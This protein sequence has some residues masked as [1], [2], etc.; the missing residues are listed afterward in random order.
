MTTSFRSDID[1]LATAQDTF[2]NAYMSKITSLEGSTNQSIDEIKDLKGTVIKGGIHEALA[3]SVAQNPSRTK[4]FITND[5]VSVQKVLVALGVASI[6]DAK[7]RGVEIHTPPQA[8]GLT[9]DEVYV[10][11]NYTSNTSLFERQNAMM[12]TATTRAKQLLWIS[13]FK[14][15]VQSIDPSLEAKAEAN[16]LQK[17]EMLARNVELEKDL[18]AIYD[19]LD[20]KEVSKDTLKETSKEPS[21]ENPTPEN[22]T[23]LKREPT[24]LVNSFEA[25]N[26]QASAFKVQGDFRDVRDMLK[27]GNTAVYLLRQADDKYLRVWAVVPSGNEKV[28]KKLAL[29]TENELQSVGVNPE[30]LKAY[31]LRDYDDT[32]AL[33]GS[34]EAIDPRSLVRLT[35]NEADHIEY[36]YENEPQP[37]L[38]ESAIHSTVRNWATH[39]LKGY[40]TLPPTPEEAIENWK[41][42]E[43]NPSQFVS[44]I[45]PHGSGKNDNLAKLREESGIHTI[46]ENQPY[47]VIQGFKLKGSSRPIKHQFISLDAAPMNSARNSELLGLLKQFTDLGD[48]FNK[49]LAS[50]GLFNDT[51]LTPIG[52]YLNE[53]AHYMTG[54]FITKLA[55]LYR[56]ESGLSSKAK[57]MIWNKD[58]VEHLTLFSMD[59]RNKAVPYYVDKVPPIPMDTIRSILVDGRSLLQVCHELDQMVHGDWDAEQYWRDAESG[60][61][62][63]RVSLGSTRNYLSRLQQ[64]LSDVAASNFIARLSENEV[65]IL[66]DY[67]GVGAD[68]DSV[69]E[70]LNFPSLIGPISAERSVKIEELTADGKNRYETVIVSSVRS[71]RITKKLINWLSVDNRSERYGITVPEEG[72]KY[73]RPMLDVDTLISIF[74]PDSNGEF[75][76]VNNG[77]GLREPLNDR[78]YSGKTLPP[79]DGRVQTRFSGIRTTKMVFSTDDSSRFPEN[80]LTE[81]IEAPVI[82]YAELP[83]RTVGIKTADEEFLLKS[84]SPDLKPDIKGSTIAR[85]FN[86]TFRSK[87]KGKVYRLQEIMDTMIKEG[88]IKKEC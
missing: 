22:I 65:H 62:T 79:S 41:D 84:V 45:K 60:G 47:M 88:V 29:L 50:A 2:K 85:M 55:D 26:P 75:R 20:G 58:G 54:A 61:Q 33:L 53:H 23:D 31:P 10:D 14:A 19:Y 46:D 70:I 6:E 63:I 1:A 80:E 7:A 21:P 16:A 35:L 48:A 71:E 9:R 64:L 24:Q 5:T 8:Q 13:G 12:Y 69:K 18:L 40:P 74:T 66:R 81:P 39:F 52:V 4:L 30:D 43:A 32:G 78:M 3:K 68:K 86:T 83:R 34:K 73:F 67:R 27:E 57:T 15:S 37:I 59:K 38:G 25:S 44:I 42:F 36:L 76:H 56:I 82:Q 87:A 28:F 72:G 51:V 17:K 49:A 11:L 77:F